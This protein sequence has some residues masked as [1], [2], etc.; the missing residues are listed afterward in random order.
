MAQAQVFQTLP[1][2]FYQGNRLLCWTAG[3]AS[4][5]RAAQMGNATPNQL[6]DRFTDYTNN[7]LSLPEGPNDSDRVG[8][9]TGGMMEV[10]RQL[11]I[12]VL[13]VEKTKFTHDW[14][15]DKLLHKGPLLLMDVSGSVRHTWVIYG[16]GYPSDHFSVF[17]P[18]AAS[19]PPKKRSGYK[20]IPIA[21]IAD[22]NPE[23][24]IYIGWASWAGP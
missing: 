17:D 1:P 14:I 13:K 21:D 4:W 2:E 7:D 22:V 8:G 23:R 3:A 24:P 6:L 20:N 16:V 18:L 15:A 11:N 19:D 5:L 9:K 10:F 12:L